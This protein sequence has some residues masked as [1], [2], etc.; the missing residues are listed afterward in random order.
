MGVQWFS[1]HQMSCAEGA[2]K[3]DPLEPT[4]GQAML[5]LIAS[6]PLALQRVAVTVIEQL[7]A[8]TTRPSLLFLIF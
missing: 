6:I 7:E 1:A 4:A 8:V 3:S 5:I 2:G